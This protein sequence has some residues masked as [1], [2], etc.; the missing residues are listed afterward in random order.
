MKR[1]RKGIIES[2]EARDASWWIAARGGLSGQSIAD[3]EDLRSI[4]NGGDISVR[5]TSYPR[6]YVGYGAIQTVVSADE[7]IG[8]DEGCDGPILS[9]AAVTRLAR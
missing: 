8:T 1:D 3:D 7:I 9:A 2:I 5:N 4:V 6:R